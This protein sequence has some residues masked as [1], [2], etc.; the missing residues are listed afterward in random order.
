MKNQNNNI[1]YTVTFSFS[2]NDLNKFASLSGDYN[3]IHNDIS[4][5]KS[6]GFNNLV[7]YGGLIISKI[8]KYIGMNFIYSDV[9]WSSLEINFISPAFIEEKLIMHINQ[10]R[11][12]DD[13]NFHLMNFEIKM[14]IAKIA[15]GNFIIKKI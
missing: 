12:F 5:C 8:S 15:D 11:Y 6:K 14:N 10:E 3:K 9:I 7:V 2:E 4:Y 1:D 13:I